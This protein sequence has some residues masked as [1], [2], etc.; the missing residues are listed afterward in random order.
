MGDMKASETRSSNDQLDRNEGA[1]V[2]GDAPTWGL[3]TSYNVCALAVRYIHTQGRASTKS[4]AQFLGEQSQVGG[5]KNR[6]T[7]FS[8]AAQAI[9]SMKKLGLVDRRGGLA[10]L[11]ARGK[12]FAESLGTRAEQSLLREALLGSP[13]FVRLWSEVAAHKKYV[14][15]GDVMELAAQMY[16]N[17]NDETRKTVAG[18]C[19]NFAQAAGFCERDGESHRYLISQR[20]SRQLSQPPTPALPVP[21]VR[22]IEPKVAGLRTLTEGVDLIGPLKEAGRLLAWRVVKDEPGASE[23]GKE[24]VRAALQVAVKRSRETS[25]SELVRLAVDLVE[26]AFQKRDAAALVWAT[27]CVNGLVELLADH[28][29]VGPVAN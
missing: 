13:F 1:S 25:A 5:A 14:F 16:P 22:P 21:E 7:G 9:G 6:T 23:S 20:W 11:T 3:H 4:F 15:R 18:T 24:G 17:Y 2:E 29:P 8:A 12:A 27:V 26:T 28:P 10:E 19:L